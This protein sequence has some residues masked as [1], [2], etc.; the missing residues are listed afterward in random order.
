LK[1]KNV[2]KIGK[3]EIELP[4]YMVSLN[5]EQIHNVI[6]SLTGSEVGVVACG[7]HPDGKVTII[8]TKAEAR[9]FDPHDFHVPPGAYLPLPG[10]TDVY[11]PN[12]KERWP[13]LTRGFHVKAKWLI[14]N[15]R[16]ALDGISLQVNNKYVGEIDLTTS[17]TTDT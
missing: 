6:T 15:S 7:V 9:V 8:T 3:T 13:G 10:G 11:L 4:S 14:D 16:S 1:P 2:V 5:Q 12:H 17:E